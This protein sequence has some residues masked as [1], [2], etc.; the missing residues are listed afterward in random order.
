MKLNNINLTL[1]LF[2]SLSCKLFANDIAQSAIALHP[3]HK[4][5][6]NFH[7]FDYVNPKA[8]KRGLF[9]QAAY[10][11]FDTLNP[12][13]PKGTPAEGMHLVYDSLMVR[14][15]DEPFSLYG[16]IAET[17][18]LPESNTWVA[19]NINPKARFHDGKAI[20]AEDVAWT[21]KTLQQ[22]G[23]PRYHSYFA[24]IARIEVTA[25]LRIKATFKHGNN[26]ALPFL[27]A[28]LSV[29]PK[30]F[31]EKPENDFSRGDL[32]K[33][34]GNGPYRIG[35]VK[36][37]KS[38]S[39]LRV[40]DYWAED[41]P[42]NR[43]RYN[44][45]T[46]FY[47]YFKDDTVALEA[48][49]KGELDIRIEGDPKRWS[50][51]YNIPAIKNGDMRME[52]ILNS[53]LGM[54]GFFFNLRRPTWESRL[55]RQAVS[56][57]FDFGW[58][59]SNLFHGLYRHAYSFFSN[60][61]L[62]ATGLPTEAEERWLKPFN[63]DLPADL[64]TQPWQ[65]VVT[66]GDGDIRPQLVAALQLLAAAGWKMQQGRLMD[67]DGEPFRFE[68]LLSRPDLERVALPF[69]T[70]LER[71]GMQVKIS[72]VDS[73]QY[74][75]RLRNHDFD[76]IFTG[77]WPSPAPGLEIMNY[78]HSSLAGNGSTQNITGIQMEAV[79]R[80]LE[81]II[82]ARSRED[83]VTRVRALDRIL[84]WQAVAI[85]AWYSNEWPFVYWKY[86]AHPV[87]PPTYGAGLDTW[88]FRGD[89]DE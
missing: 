54:Q 77:Y 7:H 87:N 39:Y 68:I 26:R 20:T 69:K 45:N 13:I 25:P 63:A 32:S 46:V 35:E 19:F 1:L 8:P 41:H 53:S 36:P 9:R 51:A 83:L 59:N 16:L 37:G 52:R 82:A 22:Q 84:L 78:W 56:K 85:P 86:L 74:V 14:S 43:G 11:S 15:G 57:V 80:I 47:E 17:V 64:F 40:D 29:L 58:T 23:S 62:A 89:D 67:D 28:Q 2:F 24:D 31:W 75:E 44:F 61:E 66:R 60:S 76:M 10:G 65:P 5:P 72:T 70:N 12:H 33:P 55:V 88:W 38:V 71:L 79:D 6:S 48:F 30:H 50:T 21:W 42:V 18:E 34:L 27:L 4:Y 81:G 49:K 73:A 3:P